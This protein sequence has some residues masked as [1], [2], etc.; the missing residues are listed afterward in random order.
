MSSDFQAVYPQAQQ[1][2]YNPGRYIDF[3][4]TF[5]GKALI[6]DTVHL[7]GKLVVKNSTNSNPVGVD[8]RVYFNHRCGA[9]A[10][11]DTIKTEAN[12]I[13]VN[14]SFDDYPSYVSV[15]TL[16][17]EVPLERGTT[18]PSAR[19][20]RCP[21]AANA[22]ALCEEATPASGGISF[23]VKPR[24]AV[25]KFNQPVNYST[26]QEMRIRVRLADADRF[27]YG[28]DA[29][30][31]TYVLTDLKLHYKVLPQEVNYQGPLTTEVIN[32]DKQNLT[33]TSQSIS[34]LIPTGTTDS[35]I[36]RLILA[37]HEQS[38]VFDKLACEACPGTVPG[39]NNAVSDSY[40][41]EKIIYSVNDV[42][43]APVNFNLETREEIIVNYLRALRKDWQYKN[44]YQLTDLNNAG[45]PDSYAIG[46]NFGGLVDFS[47]QSFTMQ[48][49]SQIAN[50]YNLYIHTRSLV[51]VA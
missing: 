39:A 11:L 17:T 41:F 3:L 34:M 49:D 5:E 35:M 38:A 6:P 15:T 14:E 29:A 27:L 45:V 47:R 18:T 8:D 51:Q 7:S 43:S 2:E 13:G 50:P 42:D 10:L 33:S 28:Q 1:T 25:N 46:V 30:D 48:L 9:H 32:S 40:G 4:M 31:F 26:T 16:G 37:S 36:G 24:C 21:V 20:L 12:A 23:C 44:G 22:R 19:E